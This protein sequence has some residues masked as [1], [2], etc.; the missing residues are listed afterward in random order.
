[1]KLMSGKFFLFQFYIPSTLIVHPE[2]PFPHVFPGFGTINWKNHAI[3]LVC[4]ISL[5]GHTFTTPIWV[6][7]RREAANRSR[8]Q[9]SLWNYVLSSS[10]SVL[11]V[12]QLRGSFY[13]FLRHGCVN[14]PQRFDKIEGFKILAS[15]VSTP[16]S[17]SQ[18]SQSHSFPTNALTLIKESP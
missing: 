9:K 5:T 4:I 3:I 18:F 16:M 8:N 7:L 13:R 6:L 15:L 17:L 10:S 11:Q 12:N 1:M 2:V 14:L